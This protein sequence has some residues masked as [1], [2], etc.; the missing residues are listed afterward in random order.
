MNYTGIIIEESLEDKGVLDEV[1]IVNTE[2]E[3]V[4]DEHKTPWLT[5]WT[6]HT[7]EV[8]EAQADEADQRLSMALESKDSWYT[9]F[10]NNKYHY[11][12]YRGKI[13]KVDLLNPTLYKDAKQYGISLGIPEYQV[14]FTPEDKIWER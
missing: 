9:D 12:V 6:L 1:R 11:I 3:K 2:V 4:T 7:V 5:Q 13:F 10:K 8:P 14:D